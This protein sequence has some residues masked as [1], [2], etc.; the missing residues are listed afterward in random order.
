[1]TLRRRLLV[2][3]AP[4]VAV[5][6]S[7]A[8]ASAITTNQDFK[9]QDEF[10]LDP[11][12]S[13]HA[14]G[15]DFSINKAVLYVLLAAFLTVVTMVYI[16]NRMQGRPN[17]VQT[18]VEATY[19][20]M[21]DNITRGNMS[22][23]MSSRWFSFIGALFLFILFSNIIGYI[24]LPTNTESTVNI[25]GLHLPIFAFYAATANLS[26][27]LVLTLVVW[28]AYNVEGVR[29]KGVRGYFASLIPAGTPRAFRPVMY[30]IELLSHFVRIISLTVRLYANILAGHLLILLMGGGLAVLT[31]SYAVGIITLPFAVLFYLFE[32]LLIATLQAYI[33]AILAAIYL[34]SATAADH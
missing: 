2:A 33:F 31:I 9:P 19:A 32:L 25:A 1:M 27:P 8:A 15:I 21:R 16:A 14:G 23:R 29:D 30:G 28:I 20:L 3:A 13:L 18:A 22:A 4:L 12:L 24:P 17:R 11:Y 10:N 26:V 5:L 34:G 6:A 7:P